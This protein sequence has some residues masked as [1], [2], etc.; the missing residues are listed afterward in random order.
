MPRLRTDVWINA[1]I[2]RCQMEAVPAMVVNRGFEVSGSV[3]VKVNLL[4]GS[5]QIYSAMTNLEGERI[6][7]RPLAPDPS[8]ESDVD[9]YINRQLG[10]DSDL[11]V[12]ELEDRQGRHFLQEKV[13]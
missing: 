5:A 7:F 8:P 1:L 6:W 11:W 10:R 13:E 2:R 9:G 3:L 12:V 4:N